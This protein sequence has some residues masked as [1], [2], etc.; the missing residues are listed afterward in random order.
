MLSG[1]SEEQK[2]RY[3]LKNP[4]DY[5]YLNQ[6]KDERFDKTCETEEVFGS[7]SSLSPGFVQY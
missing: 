4:D 7:L 2:Q 5:L 6:V 1:L 3:H